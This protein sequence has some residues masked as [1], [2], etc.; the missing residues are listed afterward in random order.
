MP[1]TGK[2]KA[3][4][5]VPSLREL[6]ANNPNVDTDQIQEASRLL[7]QLRGEGVPGPSYGIASPY[8]RRS[9]SRTPR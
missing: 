8:Q 2:T 5:R 3:K 9:V 1:G 7:D 6:A 4:P